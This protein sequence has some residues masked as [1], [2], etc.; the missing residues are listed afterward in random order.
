VKRENVK[1]V[2]EMATHRLTAAGCDT[3]GLDA[4]VLLAYVL[5]QD[6]TWLYT[7]P[8]I[9]LDDSQVNSFEKLLSRREQ[10]EPVA[11]LVEGKEFF[12]LEFEVNPHVLIPRPETELLVETALRISESA[13]QPQSVANG[14]EAWRIPNLQYLKGSAHSLQASPRGTTSPIQ[15]PPKARPPEARKRAK[16]KIVD[17]GTG[18]G[19]IAITLAKNLPNAAIVA[20]D[21]SPEALQLAQRNAKRHGV[22]DRITFLQG[23]LLQPLASPV[24]LIVSNPPYVSQPELTAAMPE[25]SR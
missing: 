18:S 1:T 14:R 20:I 15:N 10:R 24:D 13:N 12:G 25:V 9:L 5:R 2:L 16:S 7:H 21:T 23:N 4:E 6:R 3:P 22:A 17:V 19:C 11:Y 8:Q